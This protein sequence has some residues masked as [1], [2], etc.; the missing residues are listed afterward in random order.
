MEVERGTILCLRGR[1]CVPLFHA[2]VEEGGW[3]P[4]QSKGH[5][6]MGEWAQTWGFKQE[7]KGVAEFVSN[8]ALKYPENTQI[9]H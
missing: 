5:A 7:R 4:S 9:W 2:L 1:V 3:P 8:E 6:W